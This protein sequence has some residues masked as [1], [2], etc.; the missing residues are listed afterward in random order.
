MPDFNVY[1][2]P[3]LGTNGQAIA[4]QALAARIENAQL[5][6]VGKV[7]GIK[8][9]PMPP[10]PITLHDA[11]WQ[12]AHVDVESVQKGTLTDR[13]I[14]IYFPNNPDP[15]WRKFPKLKVGIENIFLLRKGKINEIL[16]VQGITANRVPQGEGY[17]AL[18]LLDVQKKE[19]LKR[20]MR[21]MKDG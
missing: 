3:S 7:R 11:D 2:N 1:S 8:P 20:I 6:I 15:F 10:G 19:Q 12:E 13:S 16:E 9:M 14:I 5:I 17:V 4:D 18:H 21:L